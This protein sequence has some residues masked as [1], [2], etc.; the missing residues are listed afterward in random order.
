MKGTR[1]N[2]MH[3]YIFQCSYLS[4]Q[5]VVPAVRQWKSKLPI[6]RGAPAENLRSFSNGKCCICSLGY[7]ANLFVF[8][9][10]RE[11]RRRLVDGCAVTESAVE[12]GAPHVYHAIVSDAG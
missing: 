10:L 7:R 3:L 4:W 8:E 9:L 1:G 11:L 12:A 6:L 5:I 2:L